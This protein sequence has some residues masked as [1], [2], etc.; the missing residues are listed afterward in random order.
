MCD[1][2]RIGKNLLGKIRGTGLDLRG[3]LLPQ[4]SK[5]C[6][7]LVPTVDECIRGVLR[8]HGA[9]LCLTARA[10]LPPDE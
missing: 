3:Y 7:S 10:P 1:V 6:Y 2:R 9:Q 8:F 5:Y 4:L